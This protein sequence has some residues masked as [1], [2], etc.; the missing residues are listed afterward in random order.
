MRQKSLL[1]VAVMVATLVG[2]SAP[3]Q[4]VLTDLPEG[5]PERLCVFVDYAKDDLRSAIVSESRMKM[6]PGED[7]DRFPCKW[8]VV[9]SSGPSV[10]LA[11]D[12]DLD[13][14]LRRKA[15]TLAKRGVKGPPP[16]AETIADERVLFVVSPSG[17]TNCFASLKGK[18]LLIAPPTEIERDIR[19]YRDG[20]GIAR[21]LRC[22]KEK[23]QCLCYSTKYLGDYIGPHVNHFLSCYAP[24]KPD[25]ATVAKR[26]GAAEF[27]N[28][29]S[30]DFKKEF[31]A[32]TIQVDSEANAAQLASE[33]EAAKKRYDRDKGSIPAEKWQ[34]Y[35][36]TVQTLRPMCILLDRLSMSVCGRTIELKLTFDVN[37]EDDVGA[38][39]IWFQALLKGYTE[40][41]RRKQHG[42]GL[43]KK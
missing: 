2:R 25:Y 38:F 23:T 28:W 14:F 15:K 30:D 13:A 26:M 17:A 9:Q 42:N 27:R 16:F 41:L 35:E 11:F 20:D 22:R 3:M 24:V 29:F 4:M 43:K 7:E 5:G 19:L 6:K 32:L 33:W 12:H 18:I 31:Y 8:S 36:K 39:Y 10:A 34:K 21:V 1:V 40:D 37:K